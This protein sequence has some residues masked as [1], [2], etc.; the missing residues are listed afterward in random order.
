MRFKLSF[1]T[2]R[3]LVAV[4]GFL[5]LFV[6]VLSVFHGKLLYEVIAGKSLKQENEKLKRYNAK[7]VELERELGEYKRFVERVAQLAGVEYQ[8]RTQTQ[9]ASYSEGT[10]FLDTEEVSFLA[11]EEID[12]ALTLDSIAVRP[13]SAV[14]IPTGVP[15]EG[16]ITQGFSMN[17]PGFGAQHPGIDFAAKT[18]TEI[19]ATA[20]GRVI[21]VVWDDIYGKLVA[22]DHENSYTTYY[23]HNSKILVNL[24]DAVRRG[25]VIALSGNTGRS[26]APHLHYEIR[27]DDVPIDP[28][29]LLNQ[30]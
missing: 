26:S 2:V 28:G 29:D 23:G 18:G 4:L 7:V 11:E 12:S 9:L 5:L 13:D 14:R 30:R 8:A 19:K 17:I 22:I 10:D 6:I 25:Q 16:W 1:L 27:K 15:I 21:L 20:D 24:G 3:L